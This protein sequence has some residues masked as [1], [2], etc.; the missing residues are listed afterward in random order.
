MMWR[1][2][3]C[4]HLN[5]YSNQSIFS[6][7]LKSQ[8]SKSHQRWSLPII[9]HQLPTDFKLEFFTRSSKVDPIWCWYSVDHYRIFSDNIWSDLSSKYLTR[10]FQQIFDVALPCLMLV[11]EPD[12]TVYIILYIQC[13][14]WY[15]EQIILDIN[16]YCCQVPKFRNNIEFQKKC[17]FHQ[18]FLD[19]EIAHIRRLT[20]SWT[21]KLRK[22]SVN[23]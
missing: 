23:V 15:S 10:Y 5:C 21:R 16:I 2:Q 18:L 8:L 6:I 7:N 22:Y 11:F 20:R 9:D 12:W 3:H 4:T 1:D 14:P 17:Y 19:L 13:Q